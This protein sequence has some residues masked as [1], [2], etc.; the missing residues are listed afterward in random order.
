M[1]TD[2]SGNKVFFTVQ[3]MNQTEAGKKIRRKF[4]YSQVGGAMTTMQYPRTNSDT[5]LLDYRWEK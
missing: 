3:S 2:A 5:R 1:S 4:Q